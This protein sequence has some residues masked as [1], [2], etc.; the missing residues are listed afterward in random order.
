MFKLEFSITKNSDKGPAYV[1]M[2]DNEKKFPTCSECFLGTVPIWK[3]FAQRQ[4]RIKIQQA[5]FVRQKVL[6]VH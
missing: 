2:K 3:L 5:T 4:T 1:M 6:L